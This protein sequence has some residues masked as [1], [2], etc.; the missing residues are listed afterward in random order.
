M[1]TKE[2]PT[3]L[4]LVH[5]Y[6]DNPVCRLQTCVV[7]DKW[8]SLACLLTSKSHLLISLRQPTG[9]LFLIPYR[10]KLWR[11]ETLANL[12]NDHKFAK[13]YSAN[14]YSVLIK[15][16]CVTSRVNI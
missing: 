6:I 11:G 16:S 15:I 2:Q 13:V 7:E 4:S 9:F 3:N 12:A 14:F 8:F 1:F 5:A 10:G